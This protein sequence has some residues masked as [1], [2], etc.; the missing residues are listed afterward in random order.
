MYEHVNPFEIETG[1]G[2]V[3]KPVYMAVILLLALISSWLIFRME[4]V[5]ALALIVVPF[6]AIYIYF[7]FLYPVL[8]LH[9]AM[10][11]AFI[12]LGLGKYITGIPLGTLLD[13]ILI[14]TYI[15]LFFNKFKERVDFLPA[16]KDITF[17]AALWLGYTIFELFNPEA[18]ST[19]AW[20]SGRG[21]GLYMLLTV[22]LTLLFYDKGKKLNIFFYLW[23]IFS[24]LASFKGIM[25]HFWGVDQWERAWLNEG[26]YKTHILFGKLRSFSFMS[27]AGQFGANQ[28]Y[29]AVV[30]FIVS[31]SFKE[32]GKKLFFIIVAVF[33]I[34]GLVISGTRGALSVP[35]AGFAAFFVMRKNK[36]VLIAGFFVLIAVF[37]FFKYTSIGQGNAQIRRMRTA[38]DPNDASLQVRLA[39]QRKLKAY[40]AIRPFGG[41]LG[42]AGVKAQRFLPNAFL[43]N[44]P[45]DSGY[46]L[47]WAELGI[48]GLLL[49]LFILFYVLIKSCFLIMFRIRDPVLKLKLAALTSGMFG[50]MVANYGNAVI[51][52]MPTNILLYISM[53]MMM[54]S[55]IYDTAE[56]ETELLRL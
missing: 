4:I 5:G 33:G 44:V 43:S 50:V 42:H 14:L 55:E 40:L 9:S 6:F 22:P 13:G 23:G 24:L 21:V 35:M 32:L 2:R 45:T 38:F 11:Y 15:A 41:G 17:L 56:P 26:N 27:D 49:Y 48:V 34:Y 47:I 20:F 30:A 3:A 28:A 52:Q 36:K 51:S 31:M 12:V 39:N 37:V 53:A 46:V 29:S 54:N 16:K 18:R 7:L 8:G 25:Q 19:S 10:G 1:S